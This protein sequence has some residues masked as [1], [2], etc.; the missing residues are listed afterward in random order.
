MSV[1]KIDMRHMDPFVPCPFEGTLS[2]RCTFYAIDDPYDNNQ[3]VCECRIDSQSPQTQ[4]R[5]LK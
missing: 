1:S 2:V 4:L 5:R 3:Y